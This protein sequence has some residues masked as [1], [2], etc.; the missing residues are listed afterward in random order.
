MIA[1]RLAAARC[2][3]CGTVAEVDEDGQPVCTGS[4]VYERKPEPDVPV[5][6]GV[7]RDNLAPGEQP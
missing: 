1:K 7:V 4:D 6:R 5:E 3:V 2:P